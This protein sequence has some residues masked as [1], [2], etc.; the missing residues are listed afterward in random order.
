MLTTTSQFT[1][2]ARS[3][4]TRHVATARALG[5]QTRGFRWG[6]WSNLD[7]DFSRELR[8]R[9]RLLKHKYSEQLNRRLSWEKHPFSEDSRHALKR[10]MKSYWL[11]SYPSGRSCDGSN[12]NR[13]EAT[14]SKNGVRPGRNIEDVERGAMDHLMFGE[15]EEPVSP[16]QFHNRH[17]ARRRVRKL[18]YTSDVR[19]G[20]PVEVDEYIIDPIT[21]RKVAK[22]PLSN[23]FKNGED[24]PVKTFK[25]YRSQF[26]SPDVMSE[27]SNSARQQGCPYFQG[28]GSAQST[29]SRGYRHNQTKSFDSMDDDPVVSPRTEEAVSSISQ[30]AKYDG[31]PRHKPAKDSAP[32]SNLA[33]N[34]YGL[35]ENHFS[36][37]QHRNAVEEAH[38]RFGDLQPPQ[39]SIVESG[40]KS[41]LA[42]EVASRVEGAESRVVNQNNP[43]TNETDV[44]V[45]F[46]P[47][48]ENV[49]QD[50]SHQ[51][52]GKPLGIREEFVKPEV[53]RRYR[54]T[55]HLVEPGDFP[56]ST[57]EGLRAKYGAAELKQYTTVRCVQPG[58]STGPTADKAKAYDESWT[59]NEPDEKQSSSVEELRHLEMQ[60]NP[61]DMIHQEPN[62]PAILQPEQEDA[63]NAEIESD[64]S[65]HIEPEKGTKGQ[66]TETLE[67]LFSVRQGQGR[68]SGTSQYMEPEE[69]ADKVLLGSKTVEKLASVKQG[70]G[71][72]SNY[73]EMLESLMS[74]HERFSDTQDHEA[75]VAVKLAKAKNQEVD[76]PERKLTGNYVRDFP[77]EFEKSWT[78][79]LSS[80][81][82]EE[83]TSYEAQA[84]AESDAM[85][86]GLEGAFGRPSPS[87]IQP[88]LN[89]CGSAKTVV[90]QDD[91][92]TKE[93][94]SLEPSSNTE[95]W[96][97]NVQLDRAHDAK[98]EMK[99]AVHE[100]TRD[101]GEDEVKNSVEESREA[102]EEMRSTSNDEPVLYKILAYDPTMQKINMA[103]T[104][105]FVPDFASALSPADAL[106]RLSH[107]TKFFPHFASL[108]AQGF[109]IASG[110]GDVL[111]F[112][113]V[114]PSKPEQVEKSPTET[115]GPDAEPTSA[116][117][118]VNP[119]DMT[120]RPRVVSPA[121]ANFASPTGYVKYDN[122]PETEADKLPP[123]PPPRV[124]YNINLRREE[125]VFSGPKYRAYGEQ[126]QR[127][128][129]GHRL[130]IGGVWVAGVSYGLG[131]VSEYFTTG[132]MDGLGPQSL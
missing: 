19:Y 81:P 41:A 88:A 117:S 34:V 12:H 51:Q 49:E 82:A 7:D 63:L 29:G 77:E 59:C 47:L 125:P 35:P 87:K 129:L 21:N 28:D 22:P 80:I 86:G 48:N 122:L 4:H 66:M 10:M 57:V 100:E 101:A 102:S 52:G 30:D 2:R 99:P 128:S 56:E 14:D 44:V 8:R 54:S 67:R 65:K 114:R 123:P 78:Q 84:A 45:D 89:R 118:P 60:H 119:I 72:K 32:D 126:K 110:S 68:Q 106:L 25:D 50:A 130:L 96:S 55:I 116:E 58:E 120:G 39:E 111:V 121:S 3:L 94:E 92:V 108:E 83:Q 37:F 69:K 109:E 93:S 73:R 33:S 11:S 64:T 36:P 24:V 62:G 112:R 115:T 18:K 6:L 16:D 85:D 38:G 23:S 95:A 90:D 113:K 97:R 1:P 40:Y 104:T 74:Q 91:H 124:A 13:P 76:V 127:K 42:D 70:Q 131:V 107:P 79:T 98:D 61:R 71:K 17:F 26:T 27:Q 43:A 9:Q 15:D 31:S 103:E 46:K 20:Q 132:G 53:L 5:Q 75:A 105:S